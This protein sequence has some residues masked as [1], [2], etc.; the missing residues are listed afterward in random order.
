MSK[1]GRLS[2]LRLWVVMAAVLSLLFGSQALAASFA[3]ADDPMSEVGITKTNDTGGTPQ[4]PG[5]E[6]VYTL[7]GQCSG[8]TVD[9]VNFTVTDT[10]PAGLEVTSL[11]K[12][13]TTR[14][15]TYDEA[16]RQL[17]V[18]YKV[19][20]QNP[21]GKTG[22]RA[23]QS[24]AV[25]IGMR[26]PTDTTYEDG[27]TVTNTAKVEAD[28]ADPKTSDSDITISIPRV[29]KPVAT[30]DWEDGS[31]VALS[32]EE[33]TVK[34]NVRNSSSSSTEVTELSV[35]DN[36]ADTFEYFDFTK[37]TVTAFP[38]GADEAHM[39]VTTSDGQKH[40][41]DTITS[42]GELPLPTGVDPGDVTGVEV[43]FTN[44]AGDPL[45]Y[46]ENGGTVDI[47]L[48]LR[49]TK[50]SDGSK[51]EPTDKITVDNCATPS[52]EE[53]T[54]GSVDGA[55]ACD[56][57]DILPDILVLD[58]TKKYYADTNGDFSHA[59][60]E[61]A[62]IGENS[63]VSTGVDL[64]NKSPFKVKSLTITEPDEN[65][66][67][68]EFD[69]LDVDKVRLRFPEGATEAKL[70][71]TCEDGSTEEKTYTE[72]ATYDVPA[73]CKQVTKVEVVYTGTDADGNPSIAE[74]A[75]A[76]LD[77]HGTLTD[78]VDEA[79]V[80]DGVRNCAGTKGDAGRSDGSGTASGV[81]C[82]DLIVED[83]KG[84]GSG[85]KTVSQTDVPP[86]Q[87]IDMQLKFTNT[88]NLPL[89]D[90]VITD[91]AA[92][93]DGKPSTASPFDKLEIT[94]VSVSPSNAPVTLQVYDPDTDAWVDYEG[95]DADVLARATG[96]RGVHNG[97]MAPD[98]T[99]T[100]NV[101]AERRDGVENGETFQNCFSV[102]AKD[103]QG[104]DFKGGDCRSMET[105]P[106]ND[107]ASLD[108]TIA[109][110]QLPEYVPG[111]PRQH[112][113]MTLTVRNTG[114]MSAKYLKI[115]DQ[116]DDFFDA[117]DLVSIKSNQMPAGAN[118][119]QIDAYVDG[120][121]VNGTPASSAALPSG[122]NAADVTGI[123]A[124]YTSTS[125]D[126]NGY[127]IKPEC[128]NNSCSGL[129]VLDV[130]PRP[131][132]RST[133]EP[134]PD[135]LED[136]A[137][138]QFLTKVEDP[139]KPRAIDPVNATLDLVKGDP[140]IGVDKTKD[141]DLS[142]GED[143]PFYLQVTNTGTANVPNL[144][145][146]DD[147][148]KGIAFLDTFEGDNGEPYKIIDKKEPDGT[149]AIPTPK[150]SETADGDR[151]SGLTWDFSKAD[152]GKAWNFAP[153][154]SFTIEIHVTLEAGIN[155][156]DVVT[157]TMGATSSDPDM[158]CDGKSD[159][160]GTMFGSGLYCT[161]TAT[162][163]AKTGA[164]FNARKW[165]AG[166]PDLGWYNTQDKKTVGLN[167]SSC[168]VLTDSTGRKYT[169]NPCIALVNPGDQYHYL[170]HIQNAGTESGTNMR[171][172]DRFPVQGDK[173]VIL[174]QDRET[175]WDKRP[176]LASPPKFD[177]GAPGTMDVSYE[178]DEP[179]CTDDLDMGGAGSSAAQCGSGTWDD[180]YSDKAVGAKMDIAF[181]TQLAPGGTV[182]IT[183]AMDAP[184]DV[185]HNGD[186]TIAWNS[187][188]HNE[189]TDRAGTP[190]VLQAN[191][192]IRVGVALAYG[193]LRLVKRLGK[194]PEAATDMLRKVPYSYHVTCTIHP[195][196]RLPRTV[197]DEDYRVSV[198]KPVNVKGI[199][200]GAKCE[201]WE[202]S[203]RG[204]QTDHTKD[205]P[206][207][208]TIKPNI[209]TETPQFARITNSYEFGALQLT[210]SLDGDAAGYADDGRT[211]GVDVSCTLPDA[212]GA[213]SDRI[214]HKTY[215]VK[216]GE[217]VTIKPLP[218][219]S[220]C[221]AEEVDTGGAAKAT[222]DHGSADNPAVVTASDSDEQAAINVTNTFPAA[223]LTVSKHVVNGDAGPYDFSLACTTDQGDVA[224][225]GDDSSFELKDGEDR[226]ISVPEGS[227]CT[228]KETNV[229]TGDTV[230]YAA[231]DDG[232]D[233]KVQVDGAAS[234][235]VTNTFPESGGSGGT[236]GGGTGG[237]GTGG[238]D[239]GGHLADTGFRDWTLLGALL[240]VLALAT[241]F[242]VR[243]MS[244]RG[245]A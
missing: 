235:D 36:T 100:I 203:A 98:D 191:E 28:N 166:N 78:A 137:S 116:D 193:E 53:K 138:G 72:N 7:N 186:P 30:K 75:T 64:T 242:T 6:F 63:P 42:P 105:G 229:P 48:K 115:T 150:F 152:D 33:S 69:K 153:G 164:A 25:E 82:Q 112:A 103:S 109:P 27:D 81:A 83:P 89:S 92:D 37:A 140:V 228:V 40:T 204:G 205:N 187:Y 155:A 120:K 107:G 159:K 124:T 1:V 157:N 130:S 188:A 245:R 67:G 26:V 24:G 29:V 68:N 108:K 221:W 96:V 177:G 80:A 213:P 38:K 190:R 158:A 41:G 51:L 2:R 77:L 182:D 61:H 132:S 214:V 136:T 163:K 113:D 147:L 18:V 227:T 66:A 210:K 88:G 217:P 4:K 23:G 14:D 62:V 65:A 207:E 110:G 52:V 74:G 243:A 145:V 162:L 131:A 16:T 201:I 208:V 91:P 139:D 167:D 50:R 198:D 233:G 224:L 54:D 135:H 146:K 90:V 241:G 32:G 234:V 47:G 223:D 142:P 149:V 121:W 231:S 49:D 84:D 129:L 206:V 232:T 144:V 73:A 22:L 71:V 176:T 134:I 183:Y 178:N 173:G 15:V 151:V 126:N 244:R 209:G 174:D 220:R 97:T 122:V 179:L 156:D 119:V 143:A 60:N 236:D 125:T 238:H 195:Q 87:P 118:Q 101:T 189:T 168:R 117:V 5:D 123:R 215:E 19:P 239:G 218:V 192:P 17:T 102:T 46:D 148:P 34:L 31:A 216:A 170:M 197:L 86:G 128:T 240:T 165:V 171:I 9:C 95:V 21:V 199:P 212:S 133:G 104:G 127:V 230:T 222:V 225:S 70:T 169:A 141:T 181:P 85:V 106:A 55:Q 79:D 44:S 35:S 226:T 160:N 180:A 184:L 194:H 57:Y 10:L 8:L 11:P 94:S 175:A 196:G 43:V 219:N 202:T 154:A 13:D 114:N 20:L 161:D 58:S 45:P 39:V 172:V 211:Y 111:L 12:S 76:G 93:A 56:T 3:A 59:G 99:V 185:T 200:A 237:G